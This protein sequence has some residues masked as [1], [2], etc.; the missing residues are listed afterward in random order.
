MAEEVID[1]LD[2]TEVGEVVENTSYSLVKL[3]RG[4][5]EPHTK[6]RHL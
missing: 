6:P 5:R 4:W 2:D 3:V 1:F